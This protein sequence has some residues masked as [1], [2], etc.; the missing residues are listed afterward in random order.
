MKRI[1]VTG[2]NRGIGLALVRH[3][4]ASGDFVF[5]ACR[6]PSNAQSLREL[7]EEYPD[8]LRIVLLDLLDTGTHDAVTTEVE[9]EAGA[10]DVLVNNAGIYITDPSVSPASSHRS[11]GD[12]DSGRIQEFFRVNALAPLAVTQALL[13]ALQKGT[14]PRIAFLSS[15]MASIGGKDGSEI[16]YGYSASKAALNMFSRVLAHELSNKGILV[17]SLDPGWVAT[18]MGTERAPLRPDAVAQGLWEVISGLRPADTGSF[19]DWT[20]RPVEW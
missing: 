13:P 6:S 10:L 9:A 8:T 16:E 7:R 3:A 20:G 4:V 11:I 1:L 15:G 19:L 12:Y 18:D 17:V 5:A 14:S 2:S